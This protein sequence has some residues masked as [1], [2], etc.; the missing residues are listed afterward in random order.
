MSKVLAYCAYLPGEGIQHPA[1]GVGGTQVQAITHGGLRV[2]CSEVAWPFAGQDLQQ[3]AV[4]FHGVVDHIFQ[5]TAVAPF[6]LLTVFENREA[7]SGFTQQHSTAII[8]DLERL[9][10]FVQME[11]VLYVVGSRA[12]GNEQA[13]RAR[14]H[15]DADALGRLA[16]HAG[17]VCAALESVAREVKVHT[18]ATSRR[19]FALVERG[20]EQSFHHVLQGLALPE[21][22]SRRFKGPRP[23]AEFCSVRLQAPGSQPGL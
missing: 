3:C 7:L 4:E 21:L 14:P 22:V 1:D 6:H 2:L 18:E 15:Y 9:R 23:A 17:E 11:C 13:P 10:N 19:I 12:G 5:R 8:A 20:K 16:A